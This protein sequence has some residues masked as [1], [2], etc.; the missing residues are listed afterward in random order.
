MQEFKKW[1]SHLANIHWLWY[2]EGILVS[3]DTKDFEH[4]LVLFGLS[5]FLEDNEI[6]CIADFEINSHK[7]LMDLY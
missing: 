1:I 7:I 2:E 3:Y 4:S 6:L 5:M